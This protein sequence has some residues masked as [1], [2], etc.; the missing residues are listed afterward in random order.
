MGRTIL[1]VG[2]SSDMAIAAIRELW[3]EYDL[4]VAHYRKMNAA[5]SELAEQLGSRILLLQADLASESEV[6]AMIAE[7]TKRE[8][9]PEHILHFPAPPCKNQ[10]FHKIKWEVFQRELDISLRSFIMISQAFL[11]GMAKKRSGKLV[12]MLSFVVNNMPP[13]YCANYIVSKYALLGA[14]KALAVE[15]ADK[16]ITVNGISPAW[17]ETKYISNQPDYLIEKNAADSPLGRNLSVD[18]IIPSV[19]FLLSP[20]GDCINGQNITIS[21]GR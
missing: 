11:P 13:R 20:G 8:I 5:L 19:R 4:V 1:V 3:Q 15:Y 21:C 7:M 16:G 10:H 18:D 14:V 17:T 12:A 2:A 9:E 6:E